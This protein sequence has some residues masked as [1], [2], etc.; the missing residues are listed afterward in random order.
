MT[1]K[2]DVYQIIT[3]RILALLDKGVVPW[4]KPW[5]TPDS[6][7]GPTNFVSKRP[8]RGMN[9]FLLSCMGYGCPYWVSFKQAQEL[10]GS[11]RKGERGTP[12]VFWQ[13]LQSKKKDEDT[14]KP[15]SYMLL[16][17]YTVFNLE[18]TDGIKWDKPEPKTSD[19]GTIAACERIVEEMPQRPAIRHRGTSAHYAPAS[20]TVTMPDRTAFDNESAYYSTLFHELVH[21]TGHQSRLNRKGISLEVETNRMFGS[22]DYGREELVAE[23]GAAFL[24]GA[25]GILNTSIDGSASYID[26]WI[27]KIKEDSKIVVM[28]AAQAQKAADFILGVKFDT[29]E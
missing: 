7:V 13:R 11:V 8:Y 29:E 5:S 1:T 4:H 12:V 27:K 28:A 17:Y 20:D 6:G 23:M 24:C 21:A 15:S 19:F 25:S 22:K 26:G 10:G 18:Q 2:L 3:D 9:V 16:R 14:D